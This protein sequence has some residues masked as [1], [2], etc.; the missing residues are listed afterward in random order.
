MVELRL[1]RYFVAVAE[2]E[3]VGRAA[4]RFISRSR[5]LA[6]KFDNS[7]IS[8][9]LSC[10]IASEGDFGLQRRRWFLE[11]ARDLLSH[12]DRLARDADRYARGGTG[13]VSI[14][15]VKSA[16]WSS[17]LP[18]ALRRFQL[19]RP[20]VSIELHDMSSTLQV[21]AMRRR[22]L[23]IGFV[24]LPPTDRIFTS[25]AVLDQPYLLAIPDGH[26]LAK[27]SK[28]IPADLDGAPWVT[29]S[30]K[31]NPDA[32]DRIMA[33]STK[34]GFTPD[35]KYEATDSSTIL[36]LVE[37]G[38]GLALIQG[39]V[40]GSGSASV[41]FRALSWFPLSVRV[42]LVRRRTGLTPLAEQFVD[43]VVNATDNHAG[44]C[45]LERTGLRVRR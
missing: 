30:R 12:A 18:A 21:D 6:A 28:I 34:A 1:L 35:I 22:E 32:H 45:S 19:V 36:G 41:T 11:E 27:K 4:E 26:C 14:G 20:G 15:F 44:R 43:I 7:K 37:A 24:N 31:L 42:H 29:F 10:L 40:R 5:R 38:L 33:A 17:V 13:R 23:D 2:T 8:S 3:H 25:I 9:A 16:M 39:S